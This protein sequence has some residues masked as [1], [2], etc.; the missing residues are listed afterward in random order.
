MVALTL[1]E[2]AALKE[3]CHTEYCVERHTYLM[4]DARDE[5]GLTSLTR[6]RKIARA[7]GQLFFLAE[8][9]DEARIV[10]A[11]QYAFV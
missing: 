4:A 11:Q 2:G 6:L 5:G 8:A 1:F 10:E 7:F 3:L 9:L